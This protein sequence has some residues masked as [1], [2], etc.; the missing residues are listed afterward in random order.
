MALQ[1][2]CLLGLL[3]S[4][5]CAVVVIAVVVAFFLF[6]GSVVLDDAVEIDSKKNSRQEVGRILLKGDSITLLQVAQPVRQTQ[7]A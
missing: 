5:Q 6:L 1:P 3:F 2:S 7:Q 4:S